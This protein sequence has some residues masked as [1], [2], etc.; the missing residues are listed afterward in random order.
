[1]E[2]F[3]A[4]CERLASTDRKRL[5]AF[6]AKQLYL[7]LNGNA[8]E[9]VVQNALL[10]AW[11]KRDSIDSTNYEGFIFGI[12]RLKIWEQ[13]TRSKNSRIREAELDLRNLEG[14]EYSESPEDQYSKLHE[15]ISQLTPTR[16][17]QALA[18]LA[19]GEN[20][21]HAESCQVWSVKL[22][23]RPQRNKA[24]KTVNP[25]KGIEMLSKRERQVWEH[26]LTGASWKEVGARLGISNKTVDTYRR[27]LMEKMDASSLVDLV[28]AG[29]RHGLTTL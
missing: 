7:N 10:T 25:R 21:T 26:F 19:R 27:V 22:A 20:K 16:Q 6:A 29:I 1:V 24:A 4:V 12:L 17:T 3:E 2:S 15:C 14:R 11:E 5:S 28:K 9:D 18:Y 8:V 23:L 13:N